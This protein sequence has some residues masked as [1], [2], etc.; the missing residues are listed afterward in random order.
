MIET[1]ILK[2][3]DV[4]MVVRKKGEY[5]NASLN[6]RLEWLMQLRMM[7]EWEVARLVVENDN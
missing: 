5:G 4:R 1:R 7:I 3:C 6:E 2:A